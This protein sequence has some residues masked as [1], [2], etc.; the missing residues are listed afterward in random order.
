MLKITLTNDF[1]GTEAT[2]RVKGDRKLSRSQIRR[3]RKVLCG[4]DSCTCGGNLSERGRQSV[5]IVI[6]GRDEICLYPADPSL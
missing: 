4:I 1:H 3:V 6:T 2:V 5:E